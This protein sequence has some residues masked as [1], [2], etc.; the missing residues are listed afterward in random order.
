VRG[1]RKMKKNVEDVYLSFFGHLRGRKID[2]WIEGEYQ[3]LSE[4]IPDDELVEVY[5]EEAG[6]DFSNVTTNI[7]CYRH[8]S[9]EGWFL[10][11]NCFGDTIEIVEI[12]K[13]VLVKEKPA[14]HPGLKGAFTT[15]REST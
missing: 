13:Q 10:I 12:P 14:P 9:I 3:P 6:L 15:Y 8:P 1:R 4:L 2:N 7:R 5:P 11:E